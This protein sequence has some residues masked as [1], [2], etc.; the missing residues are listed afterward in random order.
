[1]KFIARIFLFL[2]IAFINACHSDDD[3]GHAIPLFFFYL[4]EHTQRVKDLYYTDIEF[5]FLLGHI[6]NQV[7]SF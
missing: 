3:R 7:S 1:M 2:F 6:I 4:K 5:K